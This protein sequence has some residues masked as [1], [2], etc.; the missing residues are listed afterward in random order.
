MPDTSEAVKK[1][2]EQRNLDQ[3][4]GCEM[5][6]GRESGGGKEVGDAVLC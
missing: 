3:A 6:S 1:R 4:T 2:Y 5:C